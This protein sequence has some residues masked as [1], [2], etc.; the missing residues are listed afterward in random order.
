VY[1]E[2]ISTQHE[3]PEPL[4]YNWHN[5]EE[6]VTEEDQQLIG[7][8]IL[9]GYGLDENGVPKFTVKPTGDLVLY[10]APF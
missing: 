4:W 8:T 2:T 3:E 6:P 5:T 9:F 1:L 10:T 7:E